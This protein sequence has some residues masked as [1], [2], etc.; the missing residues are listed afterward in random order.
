MHTHLP[1]S[2]FGGAFN[3]DGWVTSEPWRKLQQVAT[4]SVQRRGWTCG[5]RHIRDKEGC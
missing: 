1:S 2:V 4:G 3:G 5:K